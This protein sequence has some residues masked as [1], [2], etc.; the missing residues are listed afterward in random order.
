[1][2]AAFAGCAVL[3]NRSDRAESIA[4]RL[5]ST[6]GVVDLRPTDINGMAREAELVVYLDVESTT[7]AEVFADPSR[8]FVNGGASTPDRPCARRR[9]G[10][11]AQRCRPRLAPLKEH[12]PV[13]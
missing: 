10:P 1:V 4:A 8:R 6:P 2:I 9:H 12:W 13:R 11:P 7:A 5:R 3:L